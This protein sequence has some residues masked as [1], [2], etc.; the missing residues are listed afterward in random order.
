MDSRAAPSAPIKLDPQNNFIGT[1][2][3]SAAPYALAL[4]TLCAILAVSTPNFAGA[5]DSSA[6]LGAGGLV[7]T[8][9]DAIRMAA[10][11]LHIGPRDVSARF[12]FVND[13][14]ADIDTI[15][16]FPLPDI[17][18][19]RFSE[20]PLGHTTDDPL[21]FV[22]FEVMADRKRV[23]FETEQRAFYKG[24]DVTGIIRNAGVPL[25]IVD[26]RFTKALDTLAP[27]K[28]KLLEAAD[29]VDEESGLISASALGRPHAFLVA[30]AFSRG[31][32][33]LAGR[34]LPSG[35]RTIPVRRR[36]AQTAKRRRQSLAED[37][38][39]RSQ[40]AKSGCRN[41]RA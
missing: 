14:K 18:T 30:A 36:R 41:A 31:Q 27:A 22:G 28:R 34:T 6:E 37:L 21:N 29:L 7:L 11:E 35:Q 10:E 2:F 16:V 40:N 8:H 15:V 3:A 38:L 39:H 33:R 12:Q 19:S 20:E 32:N 13:G 17:D 1:P 23:P 25:N 9:S 26:P 5:D 4:S 24:R